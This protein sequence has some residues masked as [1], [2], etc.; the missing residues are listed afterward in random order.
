[1][2]TCHVE[3]E[4]GIDGNPQSGAARPIERRGR[5]DAGRHVTTAWPLTYKRRLV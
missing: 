1:M 3:Q 4:A 5:D 2:S